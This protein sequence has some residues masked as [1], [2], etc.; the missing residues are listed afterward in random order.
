[1]EID[2]EEQQKPG[3]DV[4]DEEEMDDEE[5]E[6]DELMTDDIGKMEKVNFDFEAFPLESGDV[7]GL[8][9]LLTQIFLRSDVDC[10]G[11]AQSLVEMVPL[12]CVYKVCFLNSIW[13]YIFIC[14]RQRNA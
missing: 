13:K 1:M 6:E 14:S 2:D 4:E 11:L 8:V 9:N 12:G 5:D 7:P 3:E 10:E